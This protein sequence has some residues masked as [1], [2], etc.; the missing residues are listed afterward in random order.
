ML[1]AHE[2]T[3]AQEMPK[4]KLSRR[5]GLSKRNNLSIKELAQISGG[6]TKPLRVVANNVNQKPSVGSFTVNTQSAGRF[7]TNVNLGTAYSPPGGRGV[8]QSTVQAYNQTHAPQLAA[9]NQAAA[10]SDQR[11]AAQTK[12]GRAVLANETFGNVMLGMVENLPVVGGVA[13]AV[14]NIANG[15]RGGK[16]AADVFEG[17]GVAAASAIPGAGAGAGM[18][19]K[20]GVTVLKSALKTGL[21][22]LQK[23]Q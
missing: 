16:A 17:V 4:P 18:V 19:A 9:R 13:H 8:T 1:N 5:T 22:Q 11:A 3:E 6:T 2:C 20:V 15:E 12:A 23:K 7:T 10:V 14:A 21:S